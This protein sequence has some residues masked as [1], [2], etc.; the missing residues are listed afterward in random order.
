M[1]EAPMY[2]CCHILDRYLHGKS[3]FLRATSFP[4][5]C[6]SCVA[7]LNDNFA[8]G[9]QPRWPTITVSKLNR[10]EKVP[11]RLQYTNIQHY[12]YS[13]PKAKRTKVPN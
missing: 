13:T 7:P 11:F 10:D 6:R 4:R 2:I 5:L 12:T 3:D 8:T 1:N 9:V